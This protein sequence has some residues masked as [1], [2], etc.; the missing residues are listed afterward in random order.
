M[1][2]GRAR[3]NAEGIER[4]HLAFREKVETHITDSTSAQAQRWLSLAALFAAK[5]RNHVGRFR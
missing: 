5:Y 3:R 1:V 4:K 2:R